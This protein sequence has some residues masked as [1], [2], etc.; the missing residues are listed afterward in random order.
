ME[1]VKAK[2]AAVRLKGVRKYAAEIVADLLD[3]LPIKDKP[4]AD[5]SDV[6]QVRTEFE[7]VNPHLYWDVFGVEVMRHI[8]HKACGLLDEPRDKPN[9]LS[10]GAIDDRQRIFFDHIMETARE[11]EKEHLTQKG[12]NSY[13]DL[14]KLEPE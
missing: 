6:N 12:V 4:D 11:D 14:F 8:E 9:P 10:A 5:L 13:K 1:A 2:F 7:T 3:A